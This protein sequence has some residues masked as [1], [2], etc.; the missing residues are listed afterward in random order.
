MIT[1]KCQV[2]LCNEDLAKAIQALIK[3]I[4]DYQSDTFDGTVLDRETIEAIAAKLMFAE[5]FDEKGNP[6]SGIDGVLLSEIKDS[7]A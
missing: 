4:Q 7:I 6:S 2:N 5:L 1:V 3:G